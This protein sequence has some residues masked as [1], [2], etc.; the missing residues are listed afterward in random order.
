MSNATG[1]KPKGDQSVAET[2][3]D[4]NNNQTSSGND[5]RNVETQSKLDS[6]LS[7][8]ISQ[9]TRPS[10]KRRTQLELDRLEEE[11]LLKEKR[12]EE[13]LDNKYRI[14]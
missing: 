1:S 4:R 8:R 9:A 6:H 10:V 7:T 3:G 14:K 13:Y 11:R 12:D 5:N 2:L